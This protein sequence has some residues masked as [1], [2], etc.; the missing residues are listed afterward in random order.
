MAARHLWMRYG[1][2]V[3]L[4]DV[5]LTVEAGTLH[6]LVGENGAGKSTLLNIAAG[7]VRASA[8][9][10][11][12]F[13]RLF[14]RGDP[15]AA[16]GLGVAAIYQE[17]S[18]VPTMTAVAN[19]FLGREYTGFGA[20][21][22]KGMT[23]RYAELSEQ[24]GV[25]IPPASLPRELSVG[26]QQALEIM[27]GLQADARLLL[28]DEPTSALGRAERDRLFATLR[29]LTRRGLSAVFVSHDL[30]D[31]LELADE[32]SVFRDGQVVE[33][34]RASTWTRDDLVHAMLGGAALVEMNATSGAPRTAREEAVLS[35]TR[36][37]VPGR[38]MV[39]P[40]TCGEARCSDLGGLVG[41][42]R[43]TVLKCL[44]GDI[45]KRASGEIALGGVRAHIPELR[46]TPS[47]WG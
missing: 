15:R 31:V 32:I 3:A 43:S 9:A 10:I 35:V 5:T 40:F 28:L 44:G 36:L 39:S 47:A 1:A 27:R 24:L 11:S 19:V 13:G 17:L 8:G 6:A 41:S 37:S 22:K 16:R 33:T 30:D 20:L 18:L 12:I 38:C 42:G 7:R 21:D 29:S 2:T 34:R 26:D 46:P 25:A 14:E 23:S 4:K 45:G